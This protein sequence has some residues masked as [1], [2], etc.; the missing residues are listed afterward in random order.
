MRKTTR[1][2]ELI[3][4]PELLM[5]PGVH[6]AL[7]ARIAA[8]AGFDA[9]VV[10][11]FAATGV[12]LGEPDSSQLTMSELATHYGRI[13]DAVDIPVFVDGDTGFGNVTNVARTVRAFEKAGV[14][15]MF[16][17]DQVFPKRCGHTPGKAVVEIGDYLDKLKA[18][19]D[20]RIDPDFAIMGRTDA[21]A[22]HGIDAAIER[23]QM[24][25]EVGADIVF[26]EAPPD[27]ASM[28]RVCAEV[29]AP[30]IANMADF[31]N[32]PLLPADELQ[33]IGFAAAVWPVTGLFAITKAMQDVYGTLKRD[34]TSKTAHPNMV[35]FQAFTDLVGLPELRDTE[36][37]YLGFAR[38]Y[39]ANR[40]QAAD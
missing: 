16:I 33:E 37:E 29:D 4:A 21:L 1:F 25:A 17:E 31:G 8:N 22:V 32:T 38:D 13:C 3:N 40:K 19:L 6:D 24:F 18:A 28:R 23:A 15:A 12:L 34:G 36:E 10:G 27:I 20:T 5:M 26:V 35:D 11:G 2:K 39:L 30:H 7:S 14:S 9:L